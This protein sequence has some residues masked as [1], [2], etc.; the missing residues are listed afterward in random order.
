MSALDLRTIARRLG[1]E[2]S[3]RQVL[4]PGPGHSPGDRSLS[5]RLSHQS[6]TGFI[7][8]SHSGDDFRVSRDYVAEKLG[9]GSDAWRRDKPVQVAQVLTVVSHQP[10]QVAPVSQIRQR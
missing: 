1:G 10:A 6:P 7:V 8:Y 2:I 4:A 3:G 9:L 5:V